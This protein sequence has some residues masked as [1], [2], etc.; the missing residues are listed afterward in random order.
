[1][2][3]CTSFSPNAF[4]LGP[5]D[6]VSRFLTLISTLRGGQARY[7]PLLLAKL[8]EVLPNLPLPRSLDL[9][10]TNPSASIGLSA[11][12]AGMGPPSTHDDFS[13]LPPAISP[14]YTSTALIRRL[15]AQ[16]GAQLPFSSTQQPMISTTTSHV[17]DMS[18]YDTSQSTTHSSGSAPRSNSTTPGPYEP[19]MTQSHPQIVGHSVQLT[20]NIPQHSQMHPHHIGVNPTAYDP[21]FSV[22]GY[23]VDPSMMFKQ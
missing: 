3:A 14:V 23:P 9:S 20:Q 7:L 4:A 15:A 11:G 19:P 16:T 17:D 21:R 18:L 10:Q 1:V 6:Y 22:Q 13:A 12:G 2:V 8:Q 5:R